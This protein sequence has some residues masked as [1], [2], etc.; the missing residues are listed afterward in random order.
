[1]LNNIRKRTEGFTIVEVLIVLAIAG[2]IILIVLIAIPALQRNSR[3]T[4]V[5]ND[6]SRAASLL[7]EVINNNN[8]QIITANTQGCSQQDQAPD[9]IEPVNAKYS[10]VGCVDYNV[11]LGFAPLPAPL[12]PDTIYVRN[13]SIC[14]AGSNGQRGQ[15]GGSSR[16]HTLTYLVEAPGAPAVSGAGG[17]PAN[18]AAQCIQQ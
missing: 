17:V 18:Y 14:G 4:R 13:A 11:T 10:Q 2:L 6:A 5:R 16:Q 1:M 7:Q 12:A 8:G 3:N 9:V 15:S